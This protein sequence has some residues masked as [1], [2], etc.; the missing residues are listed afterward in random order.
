MPVMAPAT[1]WGDDEKLTA[2]RTAVP[3]PT[4]ANV[5]SPAGEPRILRSNPMKNARAKPVMTRPMSAASLVM[6]PVRASAG[7]CRWSSPALPASASTLRFVTLSR[8]PGNGRTAHVA[9]SCRRTQRN[10][11][12]TGNRS[13]RPTAT[14]VPFLSSRSRR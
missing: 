3:V 14:R 7:R 4:R 10:M 5:L 6:A 9:S 12:G 11:L 1:A 8:G 2:V 13:S